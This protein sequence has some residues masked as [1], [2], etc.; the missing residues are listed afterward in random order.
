[1]LYSEGMENAFKKACDLV[2]PASLARILAVTPQAVNAWKKGERPVPVQHCLDIE[3]A[4]DGEVTRRDLRPNDW[5]KI[6][7]DLAETKNRRR[8][9]KKI[10]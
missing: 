5:Q 10:P 8:T 2:G 6:W 3:R 1:M 4:T 9:D 7:P